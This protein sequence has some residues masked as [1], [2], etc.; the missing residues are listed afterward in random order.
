MIETKSVI[1]CIV[2]QWT[3]ISYPNNQINGPYLMAVELNEI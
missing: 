2:V 3:G 1:I